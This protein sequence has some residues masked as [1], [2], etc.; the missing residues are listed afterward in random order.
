MNVIIFCVWISQHH[1]FPHCSGAWCRQSRAQAA[2]VACSH[3]LRRRSFQFV[4]SG[5][6]CFVKSDFIQSLIRSAVCWAQWSYKRTEVLI[7]SAHLAVEYSENKSF[8]FPKF[9]HFLCILAISA[10]QN[11][12][13]YVSAQ[14]RAQNSG[15][16]ARERG[17]LPII[18][19][20][21]RSQT[22]LEGNV[23]R[24]AIFS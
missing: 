14:A 5:I 6:S 7:L 12:C 23:H 20:M 19:R 18:G 11:Y 24:S 22:W 21:M 1:S 9:I 16:I 17:S 15:N 4:T 13:T 3:C 10:R 8:H 2:A